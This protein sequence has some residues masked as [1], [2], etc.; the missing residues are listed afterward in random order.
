M[1]VVCGTEYL[2]YESNGAHKQAAFVKL[3]VLIVKPDGTYS[4]NG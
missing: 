3:G 4:L 2:L 1:I